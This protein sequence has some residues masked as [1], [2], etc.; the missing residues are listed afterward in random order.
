MR[1]RGG[2]G[3]L[4]VATNCAAGRLAEGETLD[5]PEECNDG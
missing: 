5:T 4:L 3:C 2:I 1:K